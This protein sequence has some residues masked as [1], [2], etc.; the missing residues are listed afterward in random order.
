MEF[1]KDFIGVA[2][3][4]LHS[5]VK[6]RVGVLDRRLLMKVIMLHLTLPQFT[7]I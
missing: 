2:L 7:S 4:S 6:E 5:K 3:M 1:F